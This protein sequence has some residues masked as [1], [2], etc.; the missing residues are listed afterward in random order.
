M[1]TASHYLRPLFI[2]LILG[3]ALVYGYFQARAFLDGPVILLDSPREG[4]PLTSAL[5]TVSG[6]I[7]NAAFISLDGRQIYTTEEGFFRE[8]LLAPLGYTIVTLK[9]RDRFGHSAEKEIELVRIK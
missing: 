7:R 1:R 5:F 6:T 3:G 8:Q 2:I 9:A 4:V